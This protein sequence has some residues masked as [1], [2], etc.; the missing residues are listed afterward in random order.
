MMKEQAIIP[1]TRERRHRRE[2]EKADSG[3]GCGREKRERGPPR[4]RKMKCEQLQKPS[5]KRYSLN[6]NG[7]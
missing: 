5:Y 3:R 2:P 1:Y 7:F 6:S 4:Q